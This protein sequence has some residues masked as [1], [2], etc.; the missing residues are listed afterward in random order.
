MVCINQN[1]GLFNLNLVFLNLM[2]GDSG[3]YITEP[4][5]YVVLLKSSLIWVGYWDLTTEPSDLGDNGS[6]AVISFP[7]TR[8]PNTN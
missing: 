2:R 6:H 7:N 1:P 8:I 5:S 3:I 4:S